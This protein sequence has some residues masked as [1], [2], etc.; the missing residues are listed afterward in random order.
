MVRDDDAGRAARR[1]HTKVGH[2]GAA[3]ERALIVVL[4]TTRNEVAAV[5]PNLTTVAPVKSL[6]VI[7]TLVPP[8][9]GPLFG[10]TDVTTGTGEGTRRLMLLTPTIAPPTIGGNVPVEGDCMALMI[11]SRTVVPAKAVT[12]STSGAAT[13]NA[14][15]EGERINLF[16]PASEL[17]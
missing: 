16:V 6:P 4:F 11:A 10:L 5:V 3:G 7:V 12:G 2:A 13:L 17:S 8:A 14:E 9:V 15:D 1:G